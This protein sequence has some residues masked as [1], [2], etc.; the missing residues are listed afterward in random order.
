MAS[1]SLRASRHAVGQAS[2]GARAALQLLPARGWPRRWT[3]PACAAGRRWH[4]GP[5]FLP[6]CAG[7]RWP[8]WG[9]GMR[10]GHRSGCPGC[11]AA[12]QF[13]G[14]FGSVFRHHAVLPRLGAGGAFIARLQAAQ[15]LPVGIALQGACGQVP[16]PAAQRCGGHGQREQGRARAPWLRRAWRRRCPASRRECARRGH[17][18]NAVLGRAQRAHPD[19]RPSARTIP[20]PCAPLHALAD[21]PAQCV[22][23]GVVSCRATWRCT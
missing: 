10:C 7:Q 6:S 21:A 16:V 14:D 1:V 15:V 18:Y 11:A 2:E 20:S 13:A 9:S 12:L 4:R 3:R 23:E 19:Q 22:A 8:P 5:R 17:L